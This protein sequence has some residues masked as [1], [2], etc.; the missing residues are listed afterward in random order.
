MFRTIRAGC[1]VS[2]LRCRRYG[3]SP[4]V[5]I[6][7]ATAFL[8]LLTFPMSGSAECCRLIKVDSE[9]PATA[10]RACVPDAQ[11]DCGETLFVGIL[12]LG[13]PQQVC[14]AESTIIYA[15]Y[16]EGL[17]EFGPYVEA[18]CAGDVEL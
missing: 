1:D 4:S 14:S 15:E 16:D 18:D 9:T 6:P 10:V 11:K 5:V 13:G 12:L 3:S 17:E 2:P 8:V 7:L